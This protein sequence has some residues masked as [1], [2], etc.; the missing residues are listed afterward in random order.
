VNLSITEISVILVNAK[1]KTQIGKIGMTNFKMN[2][3]MSNIKMSLVGSLK[4][5]YFIDFSRYPN[6]IFEEQ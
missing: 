2:F 3:G 1:S 5:L 6:T 4:Q